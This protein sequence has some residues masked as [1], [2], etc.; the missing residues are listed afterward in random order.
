[1]IYILDW[2]ITELQRRKYEDIKNLLNEEKLF[3]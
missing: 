1:M 2:R 3:K